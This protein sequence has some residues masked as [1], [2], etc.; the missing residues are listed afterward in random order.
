LVIRDSS[1]RAHTTRHPYRGGSSRLRK[2]APVIAELRT[3]RVTSLKAIPAASPSSMLCTGAVSEAML[4]AF[5]LLDLDGEDLR[6]MSLGDR[7]RRLARLLN[8]H[9]LGIVLRDHTDE[10]GATI[11]RQTCVMG[12]EGIVSK[13]LSAPY[14][15]G[16]RRIA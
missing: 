10:D 3:A 2:N 15:S 16:R 5:D 1:L 6:G 11:F 13:Q 8:G 4:Y 7:E 14:R 12:L 9:R